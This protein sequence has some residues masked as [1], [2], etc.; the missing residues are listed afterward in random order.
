MIDVLMSVS[1]WVNLVEDAV[2]CCS[3][4]RGVESVPVVGYSNQFPFIPFIISDEVIVLES[5][6]FGSVF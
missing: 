1:K 3:E 4:S 5:S 6:I 2:D